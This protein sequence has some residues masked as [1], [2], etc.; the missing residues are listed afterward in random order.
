M[1]EIKS[2]PLLK[3]QTQRNDLLFTMLI[4][5]VD[6]Q[7]GSFYIVVFG[8]HRESIIQFTA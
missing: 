5:G 8:R 2:Q 6:D 3:L 7:N 1:N 4:L